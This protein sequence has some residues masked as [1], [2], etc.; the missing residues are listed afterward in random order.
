MERMVYLFGLH[1]NDLMHLL[2]MVV[3]LQLNKLIT[4]K[5]IHLQLPGRN[6]WN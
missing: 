3:K 6:L 5:K 2:K 4:L 1:L